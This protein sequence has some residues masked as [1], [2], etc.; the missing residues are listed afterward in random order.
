MSKG[1][2]MLNASIPRRSDLLEAMLRRLG[3]SAPGEIWL[4]PEFASYISF[5]PATA[6][7][8]LDCLGL[9]LID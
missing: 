7:D 3:V 4:L 2:S 6:L 8:L 1:I 9:V 5:C